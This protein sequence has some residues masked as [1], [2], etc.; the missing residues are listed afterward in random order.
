MHTTRDPSRALA[1]ALLFLTLSFGATGC[2]KGLSGLA[3][4]AG[5]VANIGGG[6]RK[7]A[8]AA[9]RVDNTPDPRVGQV[10]D[11]SEADSLNDLYVGTSGDFDT[12]EA[13]R[14]GFFDFDGEPLAVATEGTGCK[15]DCTVPNDP[16]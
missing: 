13:N 5:K 14:V 2:A 4:G 10:F 15:V 1:A 12:E 11:N 7:R 6:A 8:N 9:P 3:S 16:H